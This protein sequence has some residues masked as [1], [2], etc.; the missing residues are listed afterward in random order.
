LSGSNDQIQVRIRGKNN[1]VET[2]TGS[3]TR[4]L[5][6]MTEEMNRR[7]EIAKAAE[8]L[9]MLE[10]LEEYR[11]KKMQQEIELLEQERIKE[12]LELQKARDKERKYAKYLETQKEKIA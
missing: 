6:E 5:N 9:K 12:Q 8:R 4:T 10:K 11:E 2:K 7:K 1:F 3:V